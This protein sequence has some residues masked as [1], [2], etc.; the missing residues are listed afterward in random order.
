[1][2]RKRVICMWW[3]WL[4]TTMKV[5]TSIRLVSIRS[6]IV[7]IRN[8][9]KLLPR[10]LSICLRLLPPLIVPSLMHTSIKAFISISYNIVSTK[11]I[12]KRMRIQSSKR[13]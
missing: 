12:A 10:R 7:P 13:K 2:L 6:W 3:L 8:W 1:M 4:T 11:L 5:T 9:R